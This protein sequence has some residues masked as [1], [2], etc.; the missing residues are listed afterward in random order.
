MATNSGWDAKVGDNDAFKGTDASG[1]YHLPGFGEKAADFLLQE[2]QAAAIGVDTISLDP[3]PS[4]T[5]PCT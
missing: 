2:P 4:T 3:G 5:S 1:T